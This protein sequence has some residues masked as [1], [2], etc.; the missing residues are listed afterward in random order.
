MCSKLQKYNQMFKGKKK[1]LFC[2]PFVAYCVDY[3]EGF[4]ED[5]NSL[6]DNSKR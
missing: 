5:L 1:R 6:G 3:V 2:R 4:W